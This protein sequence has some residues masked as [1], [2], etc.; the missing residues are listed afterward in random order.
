[1]IDVQAASESEYDSEEVRSSEYTD[2][3]L[4]SLSYN[5]EMLESD[6]AEYHRQINELVSL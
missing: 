4:S 1:M 6:R 5:E 2:S 3:Y